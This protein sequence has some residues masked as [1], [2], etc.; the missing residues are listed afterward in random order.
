MVRVCRSRHRARAG[1]G[2][3]H[4]RHRDTRRQKLDEKPA[5]PPALVA[6]PNG[7]EVAAAPYV[8]EQPLSHAAMLLMLFKDIAKGAS[9]TLVMRS[10]EPTLIPAVA[11]LPNL[12][13]IAPVTPT[14]PPPR[15]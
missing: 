6:L 5:P 14:T 12:V 1:G 7:A 9:G 4:H 13:Q 10:V 8:L 2:G 3:G 15:P 11:Q